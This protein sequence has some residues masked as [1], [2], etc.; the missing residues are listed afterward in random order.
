VNDDKWRELLA[1]ARADLP[2]LKSMRRTE[3]IEWL[4]ENRKMYEAWRYY[5]NQAIEKKREHFSAYMI[6]ERVR[7]YV[8]IEATTLGDYNLNNNVTPYM[9]RVLAMDLPQLEEIFCYR[10]Q[11]NNQEDFF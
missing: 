9:A 3:F 7:W 8:K 10:D 2:E 11:G 1:R 6:R 4:Q 5:A